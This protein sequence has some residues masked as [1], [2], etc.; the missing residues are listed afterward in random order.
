MIRLAGVTKKIAS[1]G[2]MITALDHVN[3][4]VPKGEWVT[5]I[6]A[7]HSGKTTIL[8]SIMGLV[9]VDSGM[10]EVNGNFLN[11]IPR[12]QLKRVRQDLFGFV[13]KDSELVPQFTILENITLPLLP[14]KR[15]G[16][17]QER[18]D[19]LLEQLGMFHHRGH[20]PNRLS[21]DEKRRAAIA[22]ALMSG[23]PII[24]LDE[25]L[26]DLKAEAQERLLDIIN[27]LHDRQYTIVDVTKER[28]HMAHG[29]RTFFLQDGRLKEAILT[30]N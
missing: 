1:K 12:D 4:N 16:L 26:E 22:R 3:L 7:P 24:L 13:S 28:D 19:F 23:P 9:R 6:G 15:K 11:E 17:I 25:V 30:K 29:D 27:K 18:G 21:E 8:K 2:G 20:L 5:I 10:I 14:Y